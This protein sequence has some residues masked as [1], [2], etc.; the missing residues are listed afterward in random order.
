V[1]GQMFAL[2]GD[3]HATAIDT[4][5]NNQW[6]GFP[7]FHAAP[8]DQSGSTKGGPYTH[9]PFKPSST[10]GQFGV[11]AVTDQGGPTIQVSFTG[12]RH[13]RTISGASH[14][15]TLTLH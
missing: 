14:Q 15:F 12:W 13:G 5:I 8:I 4:G 2:A 9:G 11:V 3:M 7:I 1:A 6:G 10:A